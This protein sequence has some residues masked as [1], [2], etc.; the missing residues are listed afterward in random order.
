MQRIAVSRIDLEHEVEVRNGALRLALGAIRHGA[1][2]DRQRV[3]R[4][5]PDRLIEIL[6]G[7]LVVALLVVGVAAAV[8]DRRCVLR[9][10]LD[11]LIEVRNRVVVFALGAIGKAAAVERAGVPRIER[12]GL[13]EI[14]HRLIELALLAINLAAI[15]VRD[16]HRLRFVLG[17]FD[18]GR[19]SSGDLLGGAFLAEASTLRHHERLVPLRLRTSGLSLWLLGLRRR[20]GACRWRSLALRRGAR[21]LALI[22]RRTVLTPLLVELRKRRR[23]DES[24]SPRQRR[25]IDDVP[26]TQFHFP[27]HDLAS[28]LSRDRCIE[29]FYNAQQ[30]VNVDVSPGNINPRARDSS[31][32]DWILKR[33]DWDV[34]ATRFV[35]AQICSKFPRLFAGCFWIDE[36]H[37]LHA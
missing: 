36:Q 35:E 24:Q 29:A 17:G 31:Y 30:M 21:L 37:L 16:G 23:R 5:E 10:E 18:H 7:A 15:A 22:L 14:G 34:R 1:V 28:A 19:A 2:V 26:H 9:I 13:L 4:I 27:P 6:D 25:T 3:T 32:G 11:R 12:D 20:C 33:D 8:V